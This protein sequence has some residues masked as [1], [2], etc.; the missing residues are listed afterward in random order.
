[1]EDLNCVEVSLDCFGAASGLIA[2]MQKKLCYSWL[3]KRRL[4]DD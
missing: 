1:V 2:N 3:L 4:N